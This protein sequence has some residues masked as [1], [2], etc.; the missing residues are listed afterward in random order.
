M[1]GPGVE[2]NTKTRATDGDGKIKRTGVRGSL[3]SQEVVCT[4]FF[5]TCNGTLQREGVPLL[6]LFALFSM[7]KRVAF[8]MCG[9]GDSAVSTP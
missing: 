2:G 9:M 8:A 3:R 6:S 4:L 7:L 1:V 5:A